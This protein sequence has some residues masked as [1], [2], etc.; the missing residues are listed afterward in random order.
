MRKTKQWEA[1]TEFVE[2][3]YDTMQIKLLRGKKEIKEGMRQSMQ[4]QA[5]H[6]YKAKYPKATETCTAGCGDGGSHSD[7]CFNM[8][9]RYGE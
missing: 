1:Y 5:S 4:I 6:L 3:G 2:D 7:H 9:L 8:S